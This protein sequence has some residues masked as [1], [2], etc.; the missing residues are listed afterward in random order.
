MSGITAL[1]VVALGVSLPFVIHELGHFLTACA[2]SPKE[3]EPVSLSK[4]FTYKGGLRLVWNMPEWASSAPQKA[5]LLL[6]S[7]FV[8]ET[9]GIVLGVLVTALDAAS[10]P[11]LIFTA[12]YTAI[13]AG[14]LLYYG[15]HPRP[16]HDDLLSLSNYV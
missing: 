11:Y 10:L 8:A 5:R 15:T 12:I 13:T 1:V 2:L 7:G 6:I 9:L 4:F 3:E 16:P 14:H